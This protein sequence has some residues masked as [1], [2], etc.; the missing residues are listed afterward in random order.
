MKIPK[1]LFCLIVTLI[2]VIAAI[3]STQNHLHD[4]QLMT[5]KIKASLENSLDISFKQSGESNWQVQTVDTAHKTLNTCSYSLE[6]K[7]GALDWLEIRISYG[8]IEEY[9]AFYAESEEIFAVALA[10]VFNDEANI[11]HAAKFLDKYWPQSNDANIVEIRQTKLIG[12]YTLVL[13][14]KPVGDEQ[15]RH[16][17]RFSLYIVHDTNYHFASE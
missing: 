9:E 1:K 12:D 14:A 10:S 3:L 5:F 6:D 15:N 11:K 7:D 8:G 4:E 17:D 13:R 16:Y 2:I